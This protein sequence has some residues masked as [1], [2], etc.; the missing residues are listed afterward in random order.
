MRLGSIMMFL[1]AIVL[2][3]AAGLLAK[4]WLEAQRLAG[5][6]VATQSRAPTA[7]IVVAA[8]PLRFGTEL[9][10]ANLKEIEWG[11]TTLPTGAFSTTAEL[12]K[13]NERRVALSAIEPNEP[14]LKWKITG[15]GQRAALSSL[16]DQ[17]QKAVT[18]RVNDVFGVAGFVLPGDRV[19]VLLTRTEGNSNDKKQ[20]TDVL[21][22]HVRVLGVDQLADDRS[23]KPA[24]VKAVT[25]EVDTHEAQKLA[26]AG[27][28][29]SLSLALRPAGA[30]QTAPTQRVSA[31]E[32]GRPG[33]TPATRSEASSTGQVGVRRGLRD[34]KLYSVP[35]ENAPR[36]PRLIRASAEPGRGDFSGEGSS[37]ERE[38]AV[39]R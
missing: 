1:A 5:Q 11:T 12:L 21:L 26:L 6:P 34:P 37:A 16:I 15:P 20:F 38:S 9:S 29:G 27:T 10:A 36:D 39:H 23:E 8:Q 30:T 25:V 33:T 3:G 19:D 14:I 31:E 13:A 24:V 4:S 32:L 17:G 22:Q 7:K 28:V 35:V 18:I 2:A